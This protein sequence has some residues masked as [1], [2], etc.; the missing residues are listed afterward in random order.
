MK[1]GGI[2]LQIIEPE[3]QIKLKYIVFEM[4]QPIVLVALKIERLGD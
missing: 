2:L 4:S 3:F 1:R